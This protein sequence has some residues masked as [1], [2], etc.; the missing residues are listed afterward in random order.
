M[1]AVL[2]NPQSTISRR[3][4]HRRLLSLATASIAAIC[5]FSS[6]DSIPGTSRVLSTFP[7][8]SSTHELQNNLYDETC[9]FIQHSS[10]ITDYMTEGID[11]NAALDYY[12]GSGASQIIHLGL[13]EM[14]KDA[15]HKIVLS[16]DSNFRQIFIS[17]ACLAFARDFLH[18]EG[19]PYTVAWATKD[20]GRHYAFSDARAMLKNSSELFYAPSAGKV[21]KFGW[22]EK[23]NAIKADESGQDWIQSCK[24][25]E[26]FQLDTYALEAP[27]EKVAVWDK[28][29][30]SFD[31]VELN[32]NDK[33]IFN[34]GMH[35]VMRESGFRSR[36][37][38]MLKELMDCINKAKE[39]GEDPGWPTIYYFRSN[40]LHFKTENGLYSGNRGVLDGCSDNVPGDLAPQFK[41][42]LDALEN[43]MPMIGYGLKLDGMGRLHLGGQ[44]NDCSHWSMPGVPDVYAKEIFAGVY[45]L[46][47]HLKK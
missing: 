27:N 13:Q 28:S 35:E 24:A 40:H 36:N 9:P 46:E 22:P 3:A 15:P 29:H 18:D 8:T 7:H 25:R 11:R 20:E 14:T 21:Q 30:S 23:L 38:N 31:T 26:K 42:E 4:K 39:K 19:D 1:S 17:T 44:K 41:E 10:Y 33:V 5:L 32:A 37:L 47:A 43:K 45:N 12:H 2:K 34:A 6:I 16:G